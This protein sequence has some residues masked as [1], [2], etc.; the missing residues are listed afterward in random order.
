MGHKFLKFLP[1]QEFL[2]GKKSFSILNIQNN[3]N[4]CTSDSFAMQSPY[5]GLGLRFELTN[6]LL[7]VNEGTVVS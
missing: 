4:R 3:A 1:V 6:P 2:S 7:P 5:N